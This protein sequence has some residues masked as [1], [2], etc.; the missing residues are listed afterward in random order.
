MTLQKRAVMS[1]LHLGISLSY[2]TEYS[3]VGYHIVNRYSLFRLQ[4][5]SSDASEC[6]NTILDVPFISFKG[7]YGFI[8]VQAAYIGGFNAC[9]NC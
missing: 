7:I 5:G 6:R 3:R 4:W 8:T 2:N 9:A 1:D